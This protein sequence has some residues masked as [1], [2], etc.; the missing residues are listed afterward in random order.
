MRGCVLETEN[1]D[2]GSSKAHSGRMPGSI[3]RSPGGSG[4]WALLQKNPRARNS[5]GPWIGGE[6]RD[7]VVRGRKRE[8]RD[9]LEER[10]LACFIPIYSSRWQVCDLIEQFHRI[11]LLQRPMDKK[12]PSPLESGLGDGE[13]REIELKK[14]AWWGGEMD[15][16]RRGC[17]L[18]S[19]P[20]IRPVI[21]CVTTSTNLFRFSSVIGRNQK[22]TEPARK[23]A[24]W[25]RER[26]ECERG[27]GRVGDDSLPP[28]ILNYE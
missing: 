4:H 26:R 12:S 1:R 21:G 25:W 16:W 27:G 10:M 19:P 8:E 18:P 6:R 20:T 3:R 9:H 11:F 7:R 17:L 28:D 22:T 5:A 23:R 2:L 14:A 24:R 13:R 15:F